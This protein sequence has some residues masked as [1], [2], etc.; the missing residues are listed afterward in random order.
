MEIDP[1]VVA[2]A[3]AIVTI[4]GLFYRHLLLQLDEEKE[5]ARYWRDR[6]LEGTG[7]AE[8]AT[9]QAERNAPPKRRR[10]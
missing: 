5:E 7:L 8:I 6:A 1:I 9:E 3:G 4:A 2:L 10:R